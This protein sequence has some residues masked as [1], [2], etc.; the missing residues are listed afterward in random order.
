VL[1]ADPLFLGDWVDVL[2]PIKDRLIPPLAAIFHGRALSEAERA[3][4]AS[5][6]ADYAKDQ[7][8]VLAELLVDADPRP[9]SILFPVAQSKASDIVPFLEREL[10]HAPEANSDEPTKD[11]IAEQ[12]ARA[13]AALIRFGTPDKIWPLLGHS[14]DPRLRSFLVSWLLPLGVAPRILLAKLRENSPPTE[15]ARSTEGI[16][17]NSEISKRRA[18]ILAIGWDGGQTLSPGERESL[19]EHLLIVY[20]DDPDAGIHGAAEWTLKQLGADAQVKAKL[21]SLAEIKEPKGRHWYVNGLGQTFTVIEGPVEFQMGS[22]S[23]EPDRDPEEISHLQR[24]GHTFA[25][26]A[27]E[28]TRAQ[29][30]RFLDANPRVARPRP[31]RF[32]VEAIGPVNTITWYEAAAYSNWLSRVEGIASSEWCYLPN[33]RG[34]YDDGM[35]IPADV[36][37]RGGYR[38]PTESEWEYASRAGATT[39]RYYGVSRELL[40]QYAWFLDNSNDHTWECGRLKPNDLGLFDMLGNVWEWCQ[41]RH[42]PYKL[43]PDAVSRDNAAAPIAEVVHNGNPRVLRGESFTD[44]PAYIRSAR[45]DDNQPEGRG[46]RNGFRVARTLRHPSR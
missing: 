43:T 45:R 5:V 25:I 44:H 39:P 20:A 7:P 1:A 13:A 9:F 27:K 15:S 35:R 22:P 40:R 4:A 12:Q 18:L 36:I 21:R 11:H 42:E 3:I 32:S 10:A 29:Y 34:E 19:I 30:Q 2:R 38:L 26:G 23:D 14:A 8:G 37:Q 6:V 31:N 33:E 41:E 16:L 17:F 46:I 24:I 28:V